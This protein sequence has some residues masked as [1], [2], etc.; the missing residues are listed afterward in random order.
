MSTIKRSL[1]KAAQ[2][3]KLNFRDLIDKFIWLNHTNSEQV[4]CAFKNYR[5]PRVRLMSIFLGISK[6]FTMTLMLMMLNVQETDTI[7]LQPYRNK[8]PLLNDL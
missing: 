6:L 1:A 2:E 5:N 7:Y 4:K 3:E 8:Y